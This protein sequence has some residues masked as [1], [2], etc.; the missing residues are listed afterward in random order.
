[1]YS[2]SMIQEVLTHGLL[3]ELTALYAGRNLNDTLDD[4]GSHQNSFTLVEFVDL[5]STPNLNT[6]NTNESL[7]YWFSV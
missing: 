6:F 5:S 4:E 3:G 2:L 1:M 7:C